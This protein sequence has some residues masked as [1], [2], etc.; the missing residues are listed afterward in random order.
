MTDVRAYVSLES[1]TRHPSRLVSDYRI[2]IE[3][4][5][6]SAIL[7]AA[8]RPA[9]EESLIIRFTS[10]APHRLLIVCA[11]AMASISERRLIG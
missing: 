3:H 7:S 8:F 1:T 6:I 9:G 5:A 2:H 11:N 4:D 10:T